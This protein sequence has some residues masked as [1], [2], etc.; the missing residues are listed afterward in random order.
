MQGKPLSIWLAGMIDYLKGQLVTVVFQFRLDRHQ[1][2]LVQER[3]N[4]I[5]L[6]YKMDT[7]CARG[8]G[9]LVTVAPNHGRKVKAGGTSQ[10]GSR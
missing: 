7:L 6:F 2:S 10:T 9:Q 1:M 8:K 5:S 3:Y 4:K